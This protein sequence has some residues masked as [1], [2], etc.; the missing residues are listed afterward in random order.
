MA[1]V[2]PAKAAASAANRVRDELEQEI[3]QSNYLESAPFK[4]IG[5]IVREGLV[6]E[7][8]PHYGRIDPKDGE[9]PLGIEINVHR[10]L[11]VAENEMARVYRKATVTALV[12]TGEKYT[13]PVNRL[14]KLLECD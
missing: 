14:K 2:R 8:K 3:I 5:L 7:E 13:L 12:H 4:W 6:D 11:G 1:R 9:L 10:L